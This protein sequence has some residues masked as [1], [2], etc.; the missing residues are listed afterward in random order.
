[1]KTYIATYDRRPPY[2]DKWYVTSTEILAKTLKSAEKKAEKIA[3]ECYGTML[4]RTVVE[5]QINRRRECPRLIT[6]AAVSAPL[7][8]LKI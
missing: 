6:G 7:W 2:K 5:K 4:L 1:M 3:D 8:G